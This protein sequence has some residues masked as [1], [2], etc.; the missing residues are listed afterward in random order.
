M[1]SNLGGR[2]VEPRFYFWDF[3]SYFPKFS[4]HKNFQNPSTNPSGRKVCV[5]GWVVGGWFYSE[6]S[7]SFGP[8][9]QDLNFG[10]GLGPS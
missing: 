5:G 6:F 7:V 1:V 9:D 3:S 4:L 10:F 2:G 8:T